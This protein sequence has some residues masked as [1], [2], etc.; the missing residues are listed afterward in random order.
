MD[1]VNCVTPED[2]TKNF[3]RDNDERADWAEAAIDEFRR[4]CAGDMDETAIYDLI[5]N[6]GHLWDRWRGEGRMEKEADFGIALMMA[7][8][9]YE[10][11]VEGLL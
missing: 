7:M 6:L 5:A 4:V 1:C 11:E 8:R 2:C 3:C 10:R 9:H